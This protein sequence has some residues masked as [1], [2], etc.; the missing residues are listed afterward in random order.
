MT[1]SEPL[2]CSI[3]EAASAL[4]I[5]RSTAYELISQRRLLTVQI[6]RRRLVKMESIRAVANG[7]TA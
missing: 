1:T 5:S 7:E 2:L 3:P 6:G 4:G